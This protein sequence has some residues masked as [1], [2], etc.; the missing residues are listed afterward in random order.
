MRELEE[1]VANLRGGAPAGDAPAP[2]YEREL[3]IQDR[4]D[5]LSLPVAALDW[6]AA[7]RDYVRLHAGAR[8]FLVRQPLGDLEERLDPRHFVRVHR[9]ALVRIDRIA[10]VRRAM[11]R[12]SVVLTTGAEVPVSRR[13]LRGLKAATVGRAL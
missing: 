11:G 2:T 5:R 12:T 9:S 1:I 3:W 8:S 7:E 13:H 6:V 10:R 4:G